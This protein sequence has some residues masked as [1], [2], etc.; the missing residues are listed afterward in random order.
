MKKTILFIVLVA[1]SFATVA[2]TE[3]RRTKNEDR[4]T[5]VLLRN[6][7]LQSKEDSLL[8]KRYKKKL[9]PFLDSGSVEL[10]TQTV[11]QY[12]SAGM[13]KRVITLYTLFAQKGKDSLKIR[14]PEFVSPWESYWG[15]P[16]CWAIATFF[17]FM[18]LLSFKTTEPKSY[19]KLLMFCILWILTS[20]LI[21]F[22]YGL[23][24]LVIG[25][26]S[27]VMGGILGHICSKLP[28]MKESVED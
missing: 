17:I 23:I 9:F 1:F 8:M 4:R 20:C 16:L 18:G 3:C 7:F 11:V 13:Q 15:A 22:E 24:S 26:V 28:K 27:T 2:R 19:H 12:R 25:I 10:S 21:F 14:V 5:L 6:T